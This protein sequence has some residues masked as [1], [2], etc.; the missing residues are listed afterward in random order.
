MN[1]KRISFVLASV[2]LACFSVN[3]RAEDTPPNVL[4]IAIDDLN[5]W[6]GCMGGHP[7][8]QTPNMDRLAARGM[9]FNNAHC[10]SPVCN[11]SRASMMT[12]LYPSTSGL[13]FLKPDFDQSPVAKKNTLLPTRFQ[14]EGYYVTGAGK[15]FHGSQNRKYMPNYVWRFSGLAGYQRK[16]Q[17]LQRAQGVG[18]GRISRKR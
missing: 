11:P 6:I 10:Q 18:L 7:Q 16:N 14:D 1:T 5:D 12:S 2:L 4:L 8:A 17:S 15:L 3:V 13:Y 9:L